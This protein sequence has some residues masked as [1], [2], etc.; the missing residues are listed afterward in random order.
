[1]TENSRFVW[2]CK[3]AGRRFPVFATVIGV[4]SCFAEAILKKH[5]GL[6]SGLEAALAL[7]QMVPFA[8]VVR[9]LA[10]RLDSRQRLTSTQ[11]IQ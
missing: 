4:A 10:G 3:S 2:S 11:G 9:Y 7:A 1:M 8:I 5:V 6:G